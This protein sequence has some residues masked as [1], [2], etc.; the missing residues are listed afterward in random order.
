MKYGSIYKRSLTADILLIVAA[1]PIILSSLFLPNAPKM[2]KP[3]IKLY[4]NWNRI[5]RQRIYEA[6]KRLNQKRLIELEE[7]YGELFIKI[8][9]NGK[10]L[11]KNFD[12]DNLKLPQSKRWDKKWRLVIFDVPEKKQKERRALS[13][14]LKD[15]GFYPLQ[16]S[17][18][19]YPYDCRDEI[20]F[21]C[22]FLSISK[23]VNYCVVDILDKREGELRK[24]FDLSLL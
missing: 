3:L 15:L 6:I 1:G 5:K 17:V 21:V 11:L 20:D 13:S 22:E 18:Y 7:K 10:K 4:K 8:T 19:I 24:F 2:L 9:E 12:Y 23:H 16:E 14:K